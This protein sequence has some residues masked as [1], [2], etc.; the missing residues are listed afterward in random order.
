[1]HDMHDMHALYAC[2][3]CMNDVHAYCLPACLPAQGGGGMEEGGG[4]GAHC[5]PAY[6]PYEILAHKYLSA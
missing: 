6:A 1:M 2:M 3:V 4:E 5:L